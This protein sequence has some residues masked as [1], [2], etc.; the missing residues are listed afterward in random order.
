VVSRKGKGTISI[1]KRER[2]FHREERGGARI[3]PGKGGLAF[4]NIKREGAIESGARGVEGGFTKR[5]KRKGRRPFV[6]ASS[7][8]KKDSVSSN[9]VR[10]KPSGRKGREGKEKLKISRDMGGA[11]RYRTRRRRER[12]DGGALISVIGGGGEGKKGKT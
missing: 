11:S 3:F 10:R 12:G 9:G 8:K 1:A 7:K 4:C 2:I 6:F 5:K